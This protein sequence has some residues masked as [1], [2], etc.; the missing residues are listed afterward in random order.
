VVS[1]T[2]ASGTGMSGTEISGSTVP[3]TSTGPGDHVVRTTTDDVVT[4]SGPDSTPGVSAPTPGSN[5]APKVSTSPTDIAFDAQTTAW[6]VTFCTS[7]GDAATVDVPNYPSVTDGGSEPPVDDIRSEALAAYATLHT[8]F[9]SAADA[10]ATMPPPT[11]AGGTQ[12]ASDAIASLRAMADITGDAPAV[13]RAAGTS[14]ELQRAMEQLDDRMTEAM[15]L[16]PSDSPLSSEAVFQGM[17]QIPE[18]R[19]ITGG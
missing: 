15:G 6:F 5:S 8:G 10:L 12:A 9:V 4:T 19:Q 3:G 11:F 18:C 13:L 2:E 16:V 1:A 7:V 17:T 14:D